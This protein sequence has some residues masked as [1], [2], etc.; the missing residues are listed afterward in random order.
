MGNIF[1]D[2]SNANFTITPG[3]SVSDATPV[4][5]GNA[6]TTTATFTVSLLQTSS[7]QIKVNYATANGTAAAG[8]DYVSTSGTLTFNPGDLTKNVDVTVNGDTLFEV[9]E[10]FVLNLSN[11]INVVITDAQGTGTILDDD[12]APTVSINDVSITEGN[13][14]TKNASFTVSLSTLSGATTTVDYTTAD[15]T[16]TAGSDYVAVVGATLSI[17]AGNPSGALNIVI[18]G[19]TVTEPDET[20]FVNLSNPGNATILDGQ[21][22]GTIQNDDVP[23]VFQFSVA[24]YTVSEAITSATIKVT[25]TSGT[26]AGATVEYETSDGTATGTAGSDQDYVP[27]SGTLT[28]AGNQK[29]LTFKVTIVRDTR[30]EPN[31]TVLLRLHRSPAGR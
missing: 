5:E 24:N 15:G 25:R 8:T 10:T 11:P 1:F 23:G 13:S 6:G 31:E 9:N 30:D 26:A 20:F 4:T 12:T 29:F 7:Q 16:T 18:K 28:F 3:V 21:G 19:D 2:I 22:Q 14:G 27:T 17:P